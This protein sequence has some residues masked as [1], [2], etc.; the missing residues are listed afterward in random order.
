MQAF[1]NWTE[2]TGADELGIP[3]IDLNAER[4][5]INRRVREAL[6]KVPREVYMRWAQSSRSHS[7][8]RDV[9]PPGAQT[10]GPEIYGGKGG[11]R[12]LDPGMV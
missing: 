1:D 4:V 12:T 7:T 8:L 10:R 3:E 11:N 5:E 2:A 9:T 6:R